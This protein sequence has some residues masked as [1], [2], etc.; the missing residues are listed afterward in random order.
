MNIVPGSMP[1]CHATARSCLH[2]KRCPMM[3]S[4]FRAAAS[5]LGN[6]LFG[7]CIARC[8]RKPAGALLRRA[9]SVHSD[10]SFSCPITTNGPKSFVSYTWHVPCGPLAHRPSLDT[11]RFGPRRKLRPECLAIPVIGISSRRICTAFEFQKNSGNIILEPIF[12]GEIGHSPDQRVKTCKT[13]CLTM[14]RHCAAQSVFAPKGTIGGAA[15]GYSVGM[16]EKPVTR[17]Q[18]AF[19]HLVSRVREKAHG[20]ATPPHRSD[21]A[22]CPLYQRTRVARLRKGNTSRLEVEIR[23]EQCEVMLG[24]DFAQYQLIQHRNRF[25]RTS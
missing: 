7:R 8:S 1:Y 15:F 2:I 17:P 23:Q 13:T 14:H 22:R 24:L 5:T 21:L 10:A 19:H 9:G 4:S 18:V 16:N 20:Q 25:G 3:K 6:H 12:S 11:T